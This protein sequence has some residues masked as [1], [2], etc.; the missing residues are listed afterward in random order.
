MDSYHFRTASLKDVD[1]V[2]A[3]VESAYRGECSR[4]GWTTEAD[5]LDG[6][7]TDRHEV[8]GLIQHSSSVILLCEANDKLLASVHLMKKHNYSYLGMFAVSPDSQAK[9]IGSQLLQQAEKYVQD[10]WNSSV[11]RMAVI[12]QRVELIAWY[13]RKGYRL[14]GETREF[15]YGDE[16]YGIPKRDD[17]VLLMLEKKL[18]EF[19]K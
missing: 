9:G 12:A 11:L 19:T 13:Q 4:Q 14:N 7:R 10:E 18:S 17:L 2:V 5:L 8:T 15:P 16:R 3:L 6:Q 1:A